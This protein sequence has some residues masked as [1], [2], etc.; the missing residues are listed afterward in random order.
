MSVNVLFS[1][2]P[3]LWQ[4]Y[5]GPLQTA[6]RKAGVDAR[7]A[8]DFA[9]EQVDYIVFAPNGPVRDFRPFTRCKAVLGLW[10]G[11]ENIVGNETLTQP[12]ARMVDPGLK[13]GMR[14]WVAGHVLRHHLGMDADI[15]RQDAHWVEHTPP[16]ARDR[17]IGFLG[18]GELGSY[19]A[20]ALTGL[21]FPVVGWSR[22]PKQVDGVST[23]SGPDGIGQ[24]LRRAE[25]LVLLLPLTGDT[26]NILNADTLRQMPQGAVVINPGRGALIDDDALLDALNSGRIGYATLDVFRKEP[27]PQD[28]PFWAHPRVTVTPHIASATRPDTASEVI[29]ENI[30][31]GE[32]GAPFLHLVDRDAGY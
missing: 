20:Q 12:L 15:C 1:A 13:E 16:L 9:P 22:S 24:V 4:D 7:I 14:D 5:E 27:L 17:P 8:R 28:H 29:A 18:L 25:I 31:R 10:A 3:A 21:G 2:R 26:E 30:R 23:F 32:A 6:L 19:C 11:V